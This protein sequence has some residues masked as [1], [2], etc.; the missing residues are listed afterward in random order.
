VEE[1]LSETHWLSALRRDTDL[2]LPGPLLTRKGDLVVTV[3][4]D[5]VPEPR[6]CVVFSWV[7]GVDLAEQLSS[8]NM[9]SLGELTALLHNHAKTFDPPEGFRVRKLDRVFP[10]ADPGFQHVEPIVIFDE[11]FQ[12]HFSKERLETYRLATEQVQDA[13]NSLYADRSGI[14]VTHNDLHQ[15]NIKVYRGKLYALDFEDLA[16][17]F[18]VQD[19]ATTFFYFQEHDQREE[20]ISDYKRGYTSINDWPESYPGEIENYIA[21]RSIML[22]NYLLNSNIPEDRAMVPEY[23]SRVE[24][25][26]TA[27]LGG[28]QP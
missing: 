18:P 20:L 6:H 19:I 15:W 26:L 28:K 4:T 14:R 8:K 16:W 2:G 25:R 22:A 23:L 5:S 10:Y 27:F 17:G 9:H 12:N 21:G 1:I 3:K 13:L 7:P 24:G 11:R